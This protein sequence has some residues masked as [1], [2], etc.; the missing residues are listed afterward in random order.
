MISA[1][2]SR[3]S[4]TFTAERG[5]DGSRLNAYFA[6][7]D[8]DILSAGSTYTDTT[9]YPFNGPGAGMDVQVNSTG[10]STSSGQFTVTDLSVDSAGDL[11]DAGVSFVIHCDGAVA[12][13]RGSFQ[14]RARTAAVASP[15][16]VILPV[17]ST[18]HAGSTPAVATPAPTAVSTSSP[19]TVAFEPAGAVEP[20]TETVTVARH[21]SAG[22]VAASGLLV[23]VGCSQTCTAAVSLVGAGAT[24]AKR[25]L[26]RVVAK[27]AAGGHVT[28]RVRVRGRPARRLRLTSTARLTAAPHSAAAPVARHVV[29]T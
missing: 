13:V 27:V 4:L 11:K 24:A 6:P 3:E 19:S 9:R 29:L 14:W 21:Q 5:D 17:V 23:T 25:S 10:C 2:G 26:G 28:V 1:A 18:P 20:L 12:A 22:S 7:G 15:A 16:P 8:G